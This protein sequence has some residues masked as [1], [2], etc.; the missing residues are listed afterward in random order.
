MPS[1]TASAGTRRADG[2]LAAGGDSEEAQAI[3]Q[4]LEKERRHS[5]KGRT[6]GAGPRLRPLVIALVVALVLGLEGR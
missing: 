5:P 1:I 2:S 6:D 4:L 3:S